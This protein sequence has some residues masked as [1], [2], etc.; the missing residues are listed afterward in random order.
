ML[1][2][3]SLYFSSYLLYS[4][5]W[6]L[7]Y[8]HKTNKPNTSQEEIRYDNN[9]KKKNRNTCNNQIPLCLVTWYVGWSKG[10]GK[11]FPNFIVELRFGWWL[12]SSLI[13]AYS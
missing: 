1:E 10:D 4:I 3:F 9:N 8:T 13:Y 6:N 11:G 5:C 7:C 12:D 2:F